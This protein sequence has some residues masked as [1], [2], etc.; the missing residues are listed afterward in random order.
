MSG[1]YR[2]RWSAD[3]QGSDH[4][5]VPCDLAYRDSPDGTL[6]SAR[7]H[8]PAIPIDHV[9]AVPDLTE[10]FDKIL[11]V[12]AYCC[13]T[14]E[15]GT[16]RIAPSIST[17][18]RRNA[19]TCD[20]SRRAATTRPCRCAHVRWRCMGRQLRTHPRR[21]TT[22]AT[23]GGPPPSPLPAWAPDDASPPADA[24]R[25][26]FP[27]AGPEGAVVRNPRLPSDAMRNHRAQPATPIRSDRDLARAI[28]SGPR[29]DPTRKYSHQ[30]QRAGSSI[31]ELQTAKAE[32]ARIQTLIRFSQ[33]RAMGYRHTEG[34]QFH[35]G[36]D[37][38][39]LILEDSVRPP[40]LNHAVDGQ[41]PSRQRTDW[42]LDSAVK[43]R[44]WVWAWT[45]RGSCPEG[46][47]GNG[48]RQVLVGSHRVHVSRLMRVYQPPR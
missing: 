41:P 2:C 14:A 25:R 48:I 44:P 26:R 37:H 20:V 34:L 27:V 16:R 24:L 35:W 9:D 45:S 39:R 15:S 46:T 18:W 8:G 12:Q 32:H 11:L 23:S 13:V 30:A 21:A 29:D 19:S 4:Q 6:R 28:V 7:P 22:R 40:F 5:L 31:R 36:T 42:A 3:A 33:D 10:E 43:G 47:L 38:Q 17:S 1:R